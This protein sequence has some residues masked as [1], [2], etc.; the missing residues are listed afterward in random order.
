MCSPDI[1]VRR[2]SHRDSFQPSKSERVQSCAVLPDAVSRTERSTTLQP[3]TSVQLKEIE[4][5]PIASV[6]SVQ[7]A[8]VGHICVLH[9]R[10]E[11]NQ[12]ALSTS[13]WMFKNSLPTQIGHCHRGGP[14]EP[15]EPNPPWRWQD[16]GNGERG[17]VA[18]AGADQKIP[19]PLAPAFRIVRR[20]GT[21]LHPVH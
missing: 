13:F 21:L 4:Q 9:H 1:R 18:S 7:Q 6:K 20:Y 2:D 5:L 11:I 3:L 16:E 8:T 10:L 19:S 17:S 14:C 12:R 15:W